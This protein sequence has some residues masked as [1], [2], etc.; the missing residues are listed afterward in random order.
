MLRMHTLA[1]IC[2]NFDHAALVHPPV[3]APPKHP[4]QLRLQGRKARNPLL[5]IGEARSGNLVGGRAWLG[6]V[7]LE[8]K[9]G[10]NCI[11]LEAEFA[12]MADE[13]QSPQVVG[14]EKATVALAAGRPREC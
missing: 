4:L 6:R 9:Q 7:V 5:H 10:P 1:V 3:G 8:F 11:D 12:R 14:I 13:S 2:Q